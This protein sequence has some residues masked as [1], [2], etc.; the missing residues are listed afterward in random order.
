[1]T[2]EQKLATIRNVYA[3]VLADAVKHMGEAG[4]LEQITR[5][6][7]AEQ[8]NTGKAK[9]EQFGIVDPRNVFRSISDLFQCADWMIDDR[10]GGFY[11]SASQCLLCGFAK[12]M[13]AQNPCRIYCLDPLTNRAEVAF[14]VRDEWQRRGIGTFLLKY[15]ITLARRH[16]IAGFTAEVLADNKAM[17]AVLRRADLKTRIKLEEGVYSFEMDFE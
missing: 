16:G 12:K 14:T 5:K 11:A 4:V 15:L 10:S 17:Q 13:G 7:R 1:M 9:A 6:K 2:D 3:G 8:L